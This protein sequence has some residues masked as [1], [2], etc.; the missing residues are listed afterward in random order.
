[1]DGKRHGILKIG[2]TKSGKGGN[3]HIEKIEKEV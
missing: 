3:L 1:M 2:L